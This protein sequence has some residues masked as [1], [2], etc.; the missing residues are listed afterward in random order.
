VVKTTLKFSP[1]NHRYYLDRKL[2]PGVTT[3]IGKGLPKPALMYWSARTVAEWV[4][5]NDADVER[6]RGMGRG[7][8]V[9]AL[10]EVPWQR[11][12]DAAVRGTDVH[13]LAEKLSRGEQVDVPEHLIGHVESCVQFLDEWQIEPL[14]VER[15]VASRKWW[16]AGTPDLIGRLPDGRIA[17]CDWKTAASGIYGETALQ[18]VAYARAEFYVDHNDEEQPIPD[19]DV[20]IGVHLRA[21]GYDAYEMRSD[22]EAWNT[23]LHV[24]Y[25]GR[26]AKD[27]QGWKSDALHPPTRNE[28]VA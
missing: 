13:A 28:G 23:F 3:L 15:P 6:L 24:A 18:L 17:L 14:V 20:N 16:Y 26:K 25:V 21:D 12:D 10:K 27:I 2:I 11:R 1:G 8:M 19:V 4:A 5:D 9:A 7:P 22:D